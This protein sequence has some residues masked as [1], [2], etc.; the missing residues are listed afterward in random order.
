VPAQNST[1]L[2]V[3]AVGSEPTY[4]YPCGGHHLHQQRTYSS[5]VSPPNNHSEPVKV[6]VDR[7]RCEVACLLAEVDRSRQHQ[8]APPQSRPIRW[9]PPVRRHEPYSHRRYPLAPVHPLRAVVAPTAFAATTSSVD[10]GRCTWE[11]QL[12]WVTLSKV[13]SLTT[14]KILLRG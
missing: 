11:T 6:E 5:N 4:L 13:Q 8:G 7:L 2:P 14:T 10:A 3:V 9:T 12:V 1:H